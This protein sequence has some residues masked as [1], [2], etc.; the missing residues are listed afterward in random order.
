MMTELES[1]SIGNL[2]L[3]ANLFWS[4]SR[5]KTDTRF[6]DAQEILSQILGAEQSWPALAENVVCD[7]LTV[8]CPVLN[9]SCNSR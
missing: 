6:L 4:Q 8:V 1:G 9:L 7:P 5:A 3:V 2:N